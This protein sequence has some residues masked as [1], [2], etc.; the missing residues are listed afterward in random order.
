MALHQFLSGQPVAVGQKISQV[1]RVVAT[2]TEYGAMEHTI[3]VAAAAADSPADI[4]HD[5][6]VNLDDVFGPDSVWPHLFASPALAKITP[7]VPPP[8][9]AL[10]ARW[11][12]CGPWSAGCVF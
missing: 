1:A 11:P 8:A 2:L 10:P 5:G 7:P 12:C 4:N 9:P 3:V 6:L